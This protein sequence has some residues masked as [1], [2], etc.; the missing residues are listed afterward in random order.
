[1]AARWRPFHSATSSCMAAWTHKT[2]SKQQGDKEFETHGVVILL[3]AE[4]WHT[5]LRTHAASRVQ[6]VLKADPCL[7]AR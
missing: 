4:C 2:Q 5:L 1:M 3:C 7:A 6:Q